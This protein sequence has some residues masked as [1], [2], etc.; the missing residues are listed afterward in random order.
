MHGL[1]RR[2]LRLGDR[3]VAVAPIGFGAFKIGRNQSIKYPHD[4]ALPDD[5]EAGRILDGVLELGINWIDTAPAYG[6]SEE[7]IGR[8]LHTRRDEF[9]L[10]TKVGETFDEGR[11]HYDFSRSAVQ[12]SVARSLRRLRTDVLDVVFVHSDGRDETIQRQTDVVETLQDLKSAGA[13][14]AIG[15]SGK[16]VAGARLALEW[17]DV[18]MVAYNA[19]DRSHEAVIAEAGRRGVP[20]IV[21]KG[22]ASGHLP[23]EH[24]IRFVL[25]HPD[26]TLLLVGSLNLQHLREDLR[27]AAETLRRG[28]RPPADPGGD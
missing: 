19:A 27:I 15:F 26:V 13:T 7:R 10:S 12:E 22:L 8:H 20:V 4:Y 16:T 21:K 9:V 28:A 1:P 14:R 2:S 11:S 25:G 18:L 24:A 3:A 5:A 6:A 17:A 23:P